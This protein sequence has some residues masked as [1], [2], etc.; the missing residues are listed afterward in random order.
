MVDDCLM[1]TILQLRLRAIGWGSCGIAYEQHGTSHV[2][3]R[4]IN[5]GALAETCRLWNDLFMHRTVE[6][7]LARYVK[8]G[9]RTLVV[10]VPRCSGYISKEDK[11]WWV[12][13]ERLFPED[14][15]CPEN[16]LRLEH[17]PPVPMVAK[18]A[19]IN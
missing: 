5:N 9:G 8:Q 19:L 1:S 10:H 17:I 11:R 4:A 14:C 18:H 13:N 3:K 15:R 12:V 7:A 2:L 16:L 6:E